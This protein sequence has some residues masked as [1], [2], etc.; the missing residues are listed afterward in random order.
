M[1][2]SVSRWSDKKLPDR[3]VTNTGHSRR[4]WPDHSEGGGHR[5]KLNKGINT[6]PNLVP[7]VIVQKEQRATLRSYQLSFPSP[8]PQTVP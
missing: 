3:D 2:R 4:R 7:Y 5:G 8:A 1:R 6:R